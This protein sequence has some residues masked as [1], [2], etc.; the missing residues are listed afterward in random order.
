MKKHP[1]KIETTSSTQ[2]IPQLW[3]AEGGG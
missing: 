3:G 2:W 1:E